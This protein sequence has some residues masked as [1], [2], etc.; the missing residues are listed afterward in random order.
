MSKARI[1]LAI[2]AVGLIAL[3]WA[4]TS[5]T[6]KIAETPET[7]KV[8]KEFILDLAHEDYE[9]AAALAVP[10]L[11]GPESIVAL[12]DMVAQNSDILNN[13]TEVHLT[14]RGFNDAVRYAYGTIN[15]GNVE[16]PLYI[17]FRDIDGATRV[18]YVSFNEDAIPTFDNSTDSAE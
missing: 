2:L 3:I 16:A 10:E 15:S 17:E 4:A 6:K 8:G 18:S 1:I 11:Q 9:G 7:F 5:F 12:Q 14:G 13:K